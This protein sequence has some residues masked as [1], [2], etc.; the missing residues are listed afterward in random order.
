MYNDKQQVL[1]IAQAQLMHIEQDTH[2]QVTNGKVRNLASLHLQSANALGNSLIL[3]MEDVNIIMYRMKRHVDSGKSIDIAMPSGQNALPKNN[4]D[5]RTI[6]LDEHLMPYQMLVTSFYPWTTLFTKAVLIFHDVEGMQCHAFRPLPSRL[7][8]CE[9]TLDEST[10]CQTCV[11]KTKDMHSM[12]S[13]GIEIP[14]SQE[15]KSSQSIVG[16]TQPAKQY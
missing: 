12:V 5:K 1:E 3:V 14:V 16:T 11:M 8:F 4:K 2:D 7:K 9:R 13:K 6:G 15:W 10:I